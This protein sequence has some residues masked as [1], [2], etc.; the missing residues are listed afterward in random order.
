M[1]FRSYGLGN[2][3]AVQLYLQYHTK[4]NIQDN[5]LVTTDQ[6][7]TSERCPEK[8]LFLKSEKRQRV[9]KNGRNP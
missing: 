8:Q 6:K 5:N 9:L 7:Q 2:A 3:I 1:K 4:G